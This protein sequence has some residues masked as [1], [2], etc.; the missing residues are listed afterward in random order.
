[1]LRAT[2][3]IDNF[4]ALSY[5]GTWNASTNTPTLTS[6]V[7]TAGYYYIVSV[8]GSTSLN[9]VSTWNV[10]DWVIFS[11]TGVWQRIAGGLTG[12]VNIANDTSGNV[13]YNLV[14]TN[15]NSGTVST[16]DVDSPNLTF[17]PSTS[18]LKT[19][20]TLIGPS[21]VGTVPL[22]ISAET[23]TQLNLVPTIGVTN[24]D[25]LWI[26]A[27]DG[28]SADFGIYNY[29]LFADAAQI[30]FYMSATNTVYDKGNPVFLVNQYGSAQFGTAAGANS[31]YGTA[32][33]VLTSNG[34]SAAPSWTGGGA[35]KTSNGYAYLPNGLLLQWGTVANLPNGAT[36][37]ISLPIAFPNGC[38]NVVCSFGNVPPNTG[39]VGGSPGPDNSH[40]Y[41]GNSAI[42]PNQ[43]L[44][45]A[46]GY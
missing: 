35:S 24:T 11:N 42:G 29:S 8:A 41:L 3:S 13:N 14:L 39:A 30:G 12:S 37:L 27:Y 1:M 26:A 6:S 18:T 44:W 10:G 19:P 22:V 46:I 43:V 16:F 5:Q 20:A 33:Q 21:P 17:N 25:W 4:S 32:G 36:Q 34:S 40:I 28:F 38:L 45:T 7:G 23:S 2:T 31:G 9:G 15:A